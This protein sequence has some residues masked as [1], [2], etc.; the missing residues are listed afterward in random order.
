M[1]DGI[2][3]LGA[4]EDMSKGLPVRAPAPAPTGS[5]IVIRE[6]DLRTPAGITTCTVLP[7][8]PSTRS[9]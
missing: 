2:A 7:D 5:T 9:W 4:A 1:R 8:S 3:T 6:V